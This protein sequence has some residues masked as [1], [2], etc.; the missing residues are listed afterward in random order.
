[1]MNLEIRRLQLITWRVLVGLVFE[2]AQEEVG[3]R[4]WPVFS[5]LDSR[6]APLYVLEHTF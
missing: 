6:P 4:F 5:P 2:A 3:D 1:M